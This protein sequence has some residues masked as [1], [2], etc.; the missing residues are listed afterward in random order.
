MIFFQKHVVMALLLFL[1]EHCISPVL[2]LIPLPHQFL[3]QNEE[4]FANLQEGEKKLQDYSF[5]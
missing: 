3:P 1:L 2:E 5:T 4:L